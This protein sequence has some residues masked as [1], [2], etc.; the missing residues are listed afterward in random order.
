MSILVGIAVDEGRLRLDQTLPELLP[1]HADRMSDE[2][3]L[4]TLRHLLAMTSGIS[5][6]DRGSTLV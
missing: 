2:A 4:V 3:R 5:G 1:A 6:A